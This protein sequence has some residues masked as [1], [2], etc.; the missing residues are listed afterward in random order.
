[1]RPPARTSV[2]LRGLAEFGARRAHPRYRPGPG[3]PV[4]ADRIET[5]E[6]QGAPL[7]RL[8]PPIRWPGEAR[9]PLPAPRLGEHTVPCLAEAG[10]TAAEIGELRSS[11][12]I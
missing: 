9:I 12:V 7:R 3:N 1:M 10:F 11:G 4:A 8:A 6:A 5:V 2:G